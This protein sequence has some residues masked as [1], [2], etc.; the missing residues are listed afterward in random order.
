M[1]DEK[2]EMNY[3]VERIE[4]AFRYLVTGSWAY[5]ILWFCYKKL[6]VSIYK[7][8]GNALL[9]VSTFVIGASFYFIYRSII[10][11][12]ILKEIDR[13]QKENPRSYI[14]SKYYSNDFDKCHD[15]W[16]KAYSETSNIDQDR[17]EIW[18]ASIHMMN[19]MAIICLLGILIMFF[20]GFS[21]IKLFLLSILSIL[22]SYSALES[23]KDLQRR[24]YMEVKNIDGKKLQAI[25]D[26]YN[27]SIPETANNNSEDPRPEIK[28]EN[29]V[30]NDRR[31][32]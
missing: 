4:N 24:L 3:K 6:F 12:F 11:P 32:K 26:N 21:W 9:I 28:A 15:V 2:F 27:K 8:I 22:L 10:Y 7:D 13:R 16:K 30:E 25:V 20:G 31:F 5:M 19:M 14:K 17:Y 23:D 1:A 29:L 18:Y